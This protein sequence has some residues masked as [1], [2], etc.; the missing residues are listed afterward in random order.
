MAD[1]IGNVNHDGHRAGAEANAADVAVSN[2]KDPVGAG[3]EGGNKFAQT[4]HNAGRLDPA[5][6]GRDLEE[7]LDARLRDV[8]AAVG[9]QEVD[10]GLCRDRVCRDPLA[11]LEGEVGPCGS[12][13]AAGEVVEAAHR[14]AHIL[15]GGTEL[16][17]EGAAEAVLEARDGAAHRAGRVHVEGDVALTNGGA[18]VERLLLRVA[19]EGQ[20]EEEV[21]VVGDALCRVAGLVLVVGSA[22]GPLD[23]VGEPVTVRVGV[24][25]LARVAGAAPLVA[26]ADAVRV[27][28]HVLVVGRVVVVGIGRQEHVAETER[29]DLLAVEP[30]VVVA[31]GVGP[32]G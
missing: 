8:V 28:L 5:I 14:E 17:N 13:S 24:G 19:V 21:D 1:S 31:V 25:P 7:R 16:G 4:G 18:E 30:A 15:D 6:A 32:R 27:G 9:G 12:P 29:I 2:A 3:V 10:A 20:R 23:E 11:E 22:E 26:V